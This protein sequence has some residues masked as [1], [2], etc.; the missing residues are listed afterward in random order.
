MKKNYLK[1]LSSALALS[2]VLGSCGNK[3]DDNSENTS[4]TE[5]TQTAA[6]TE[7]DEEQK[8]SNEEAESTEGENKKESDDANSSESEVTLADWEG[9]WNGMQLYLDK[10][11]LDET[12]EQ[13]GEKEGKSADEAKKAYKEKR[14]FD[15][16]GLKIEGDTL[17]AYDNFPSESG[18]KE[19]ETSEY[20]WV[21]SH[22][23]EHD[24]HKLNFE[25]FKTDNPDAKYPVMLLM[26]VHGEEE[27]TH[28]HL[29]AG[30]DADELMKKEGW[31]P[32]F[33][34]PNTTMDQIKDEILE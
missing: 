27:M 31:F 24:G 29:R 26:P 1:V 33:V 20:K 25:E 5:Q 34:K 12:W 17:I 6:S 8:D 9:E 16:G 4:K 15:F 19:L 21:K 14:D 28:F 32:T 7:E 18:A 3:S 23:M 22:E 2:L 13:L 11:E 10:D 30:D